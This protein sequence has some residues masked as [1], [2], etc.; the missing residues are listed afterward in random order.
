MSLRR[1]RAVLPYGVACT[2]MTSGVE[3]GRAL[4]QCEDCCA[5]GHSGLRVDVDL[6]ADRSLATASQ[7][8]AAVT[9]SSG[10]VMWER[11]LPSQS[12]PQATDGE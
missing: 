1:L 12:P 10:G 3:L 8:I 4:A 7:I 11:D 9:N 5:H 6:L 2:I